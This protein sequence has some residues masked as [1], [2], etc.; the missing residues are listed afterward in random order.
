MPDARAVAEVLGLDLELAG[1]RV[2]GVSPADRPRP[3]TLSFTRRWDA[4]MARTVATHPDTVF[5][6]P[7][8][9]GA[10]GPNLV[11][12]TNPRLAYA[13]VVRDLLAPPVVPGIADTAVVKPG[14]VLGADVTV[15]D[16]VVIED[17]VLIGDRCTVDAHSLL[18]RGT[19]IGDDC[20]IGAHV[21]L[22][23]AGFGYEQGADGVP[24]HIP[25]LGGLEIGDRVEIGDH[26]SIAR[27]TVESTRVEDDV[28]IDDHV[29]IAHN[30]RIGARSFV[31]AGAEISG[32]VDIGTN[33]WVSPEVTIVNKVTVGDDALLG[34]GAV[35]IKDVPANAIVA[36]VPAQYLRDRFA[37]DPGAR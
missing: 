27:G 7:A 32:S 26:V 16:Y 12:V 31:I 30:A 25:H 5:L 33:V 19:V 29:F 13:H 21:C 36:G 2:D 9:A 28:K 34:I 37:Q 1:L 3:H 22:G 24:V 15:G 35:V 23:G 6:V 10:S 11:P 14:A 18:R 17:G 20:R 4:A 8:D